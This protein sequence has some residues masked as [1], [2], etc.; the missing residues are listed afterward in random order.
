[1]AL[2]WKKS[3]RPEAPAEVRPELPALYA[4]PEAAPKRDKQLNVKVSEDVRAMFGQIA[5]A[6]GLSA[7]ALFEEMVSEKVALMVHEGRLKL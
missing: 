4:V 2:L 1:M 7:A 5:E 6:R 3:A